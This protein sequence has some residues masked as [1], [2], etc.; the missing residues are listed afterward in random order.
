[1]ITIGYVRA[2][3]CQRPVEDIFEDIETYAKR[4]NDAE[5][6]GLGVQGVFLDET[7]NLYT[8]ETKQYLDAIDQKAKGTGGIIGHRF[9]SQFQMCE[10]YVH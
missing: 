7:T 9:V 4:S 10:K 2:T 6:G 1:M 5:H 8:E 3:Y